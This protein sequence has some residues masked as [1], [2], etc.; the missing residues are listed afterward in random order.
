VARRAP[1][2]AVAQVEGQSRPKRSGAGSSP[3]SGARYRD[4]LV[5]GREPLELTMQVR[6]LLPVPLC[7]RS[8]IGIAV[9]FDEV[10]VRAG[11]AAP[12]PLRRPSRR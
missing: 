11:P 2:A 6:P 4:R 8:V 12:A 1:H 5:V 7:R 9:A 10:P 3:A